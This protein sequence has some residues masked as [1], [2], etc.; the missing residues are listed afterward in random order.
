MIFK[1][2]TASHTN[3]FELGQHGRSR[4]NVWRYAGVNAF[5]SERRE[6]LDLHPTVKPVEMIAD[7][8]LD[9]TARGEA[10]LD[11]FV[12]SGTTIIA[13]E[14]T[15]RRAYAIEIDPQYADVIIRRWQAYT[16]R[17]AILETTGETFGAVEK[18]AID[19]A[20][21]SLEDAS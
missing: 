6:E 5:K 19:A 17:D 11:P 10:V 21:K 16:G 13:A 15:G 12:G 14:K 2:G 9:C 4:T 8:L 18:Q 3:T 7:V 1:K 20:A